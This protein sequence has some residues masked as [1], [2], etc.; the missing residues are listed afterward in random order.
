[1]VELL[2]DLKSYLDNY[3][4]SDEIF[5]GIKIVESNLYNNLLE[6]EQITIM[7]QNEFEEVRYTTLDNAE[8][9]NVAVQ[10]NCYGSQ[11]NLNGKRKT[12]YSM[13]ALLADNV[14]KAFDK[15]KLSRANKN[16]K[17]CRKVMTT[18]PMPLKEGSQVY[19][20]VVRFQLLVDYDYQK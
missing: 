4:S 18:S 13:S 20:T 14:S 6:K 5:N 19:V 9:N 16:I 12:A 15:V 3:F 8:I 10:I 1:M 17:G 7:I 2:E 11:K